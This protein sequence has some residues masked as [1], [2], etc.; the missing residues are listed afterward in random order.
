MSFELI[1]FSHNTKLPKTGMCTAHIICDLLP[2]RR[3]NSY[4]TGQDAGHGQQVDCH[5][6]FI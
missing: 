6:P 2:I 3:P 5:G 4:S 1:T